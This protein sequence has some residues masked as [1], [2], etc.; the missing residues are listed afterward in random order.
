M[1]DRKFTF[2][3]LSQ[4]LHHHLLWFLISAYAIAAVYP[5]GGLWIRSISFGDSTIFHEK[6]HISL[7]MLML[8]SLMFNAGLGVKT[9]HLQD[10]MHK[11]RMLAAGLVANLAIPMAYIF[12]VTLV[13]RL[14]YE[15]D[16]AQHIL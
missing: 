6:T 3:A 13:M 16:E 14:W 2:L 9:S 15:P 11:Q 12:G 10:V 4:F 8:D 7:L 1:V 5:T